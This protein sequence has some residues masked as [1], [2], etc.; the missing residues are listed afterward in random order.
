MNYR[1][2]LLQELKGKPT[3]KNRKEKRGGGVYSKDNIDVVKYVERH[4]VTK[5]WDIFC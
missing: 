1:L 5:L 2:C 3:S 4:M